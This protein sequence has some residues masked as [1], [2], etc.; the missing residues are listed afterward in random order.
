MQDTKLVNAEKLNIDHWELD[1]DVE[2]TIQQLMIDEIKAAFVAVFNSE[3]TYV[4]LPFQYSDEDV[5]DPRIIHIISECWGVPAN[6]AAIEFNLEDII[7]DAATNKYE[8]NAPLLNMLK[9]IIEKIE[10]I[11]DE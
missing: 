3:L 6:G 7:M 1:I 5:S 11:G 2:K 10:N 4:S 8:D 9:S